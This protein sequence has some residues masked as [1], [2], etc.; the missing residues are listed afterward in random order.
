MSVPISLHSRFCITSRPSAES[1]ILATCPNSSID[2][3]IAPTMAPFMAITQ[4]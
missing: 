1:D 2:G 3:P 4:K